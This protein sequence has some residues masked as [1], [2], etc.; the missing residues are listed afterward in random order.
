MTATL[1]PH[2]RPYGP[3]TDELRGLAVAT[4]AQLVADGAGRVEAIDEVARRLE[5]HP[6]S[7]RNWI[8]AARPAAAPPT[9]EQAAALAAQ[10]RHTLA[11]MTARAG[12]YLHTPPNKETQR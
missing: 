8:R 9:P 5:V 10:R 3:I 11:A 7:V 4:V 12:H 2:Q 6:N 1:C